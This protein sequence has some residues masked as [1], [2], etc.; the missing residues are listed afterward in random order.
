MQKPIRVRPRRIHFFS[1]IASHQSR[2]FL[3]F[4]TFGNEAFWTDAAHVPEGMMADHV[5][6]MKVM[7]IGLSLEEQWTTMQ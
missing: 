7:S 1:T 3:R 6:P 5:T 2:L 4:E